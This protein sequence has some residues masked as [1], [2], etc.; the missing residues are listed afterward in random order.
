MLC[1]QESETLE[2]SMSVCEHW[3]TL[4]VLTVGLQEEIVMLGVPPVGL[5]EEISRK[6]AA[7][8]EGRIFNIL[9]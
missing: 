6:A 3:L 8:P 4:G 2:Q 5:Q 1:S 7:D 9:G